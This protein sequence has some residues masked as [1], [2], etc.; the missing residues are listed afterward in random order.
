MASVITLLFA[1]SYLPWF[2]KDRK[3]KKLVVEDSEEEMCAFSAGEDATEKIA[4][5]K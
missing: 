1:L 4:I 3:A 2:V 5:N